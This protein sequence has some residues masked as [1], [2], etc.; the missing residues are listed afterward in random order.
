MPSSLPPRPRSGLSILGVCVSLLA[1]AL[2][3]SL[4]IPAFFERPSVTLESATKLFAKDVTDLQNQAVL[5][6]ETVELRFLDGGD[7][8]SGHHRDGRL[9]PAPTGDSTFRREYSFNA[10]FQGVRMDIIELGQGNSLHFDRQGHAMTSLRV[11]F[12]YEGGTCEVRVVEGTG[13][14]IIDDVVETE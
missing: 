6:F 10:V 9:L 3:S 5:G 4:A 11:V 12:A 1:I 7:G 14:V 13:R 2:I 8:Y